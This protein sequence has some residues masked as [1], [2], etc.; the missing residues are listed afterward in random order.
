[1]ELRFP[2]ENNKNY[3][4]NLIPSNN[5]DIN[6]DKQ[7]DFLIKYRELFGDSLSEVEL[8]DIFEKHN[9]NETKIIKEINSLLSKDNERKIYDYNDNNNYNYNDNNNSRENHSPSFAHNSNSKSNTLKNRKEIYIYESEIPSDYPPPPKNKENTNII[10]RNTLLKYKKF[11]FKELKRKNNT[12]KENNYK[13]DELNFD[14]IKINKTEYNSNKEKVKE[15]QLIGLYKKNN[16]KP[17]YQSIKRNSNYQENNITKEQKKKYMQYF[18]GNIKN[19]SRNS[20]NNKKDNKGKSPD[21][22]RRNNILNITPDI[23]DYN[24]KKVLTYKKGMRTY[25]LNKRSSYS[26]LKIVY[27]IN[28]FF[29][30]ACYENPQREQLLKIINEKRHQN[31]DKI[32][33]IIFPQISPIGSFPFYSNLYPPYNQFNPYMN[34]YMYM[35]SPPIQYPLQNSFNSEIM[36]KQ[37]QNSNNIEI[38]QNF[39]NNI[40]SNANGQEFINSLNNNEIIQLN[41]NL[42]NNQSKNNSNQNSLLMNNIGTHSYYNQKSSGNISN[43]GNINTTSSF[44]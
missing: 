13:K 16:I 3:R 8:L 14:D 42:V 24:G 34:M 21:F 17:K 5:D 29:I 32:I 30:P 2:K 39:N 1:M 28:D 38:R 35:P 22:G 19:Y 9:Y 15:K 31:P 37:L 7:K 41:N 26:Y 44:K 36:N 11:L 18:F 33:E 27:K 12:F 43:S 20:K 6:I 40:A 25:C 10:N 4:T 23:T